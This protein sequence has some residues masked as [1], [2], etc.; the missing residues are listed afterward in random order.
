MPSA[1]ALVLSRAVHRARVD[2]AGVRSTVLS[3]GGSTARRVAVL[4]DLMTIESRAFHAARVA[5]QAAEAPVVPCVAR[6]FGLCDCPRCCRAR[7]PRR[8]TRREALSM[9]R[10]MGA[11]GD[12]GWRAYAIEHRIGYAVA[13]ATVNEGRALAVAS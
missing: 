10:T 11:R 13:L 8:T 5:R 3:A 2:R 9:L 12:A 6:R 1:A 7:A 4:A